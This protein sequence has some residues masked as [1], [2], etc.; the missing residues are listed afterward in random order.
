MILG[1]V[2]GEYNNITAV[3]VIHRDSIACLI[4]QHGPTVTTITTL[5]AHE[6]PTGR[7]RWQRV[8][9]VQVATE[10]VCT[11]PEGCTTAL[12]DAGAPRSEDMRMCISPHRSTTRYLQ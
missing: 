4:N 2:S 6:P 12:S 10:Y 8:Q 9:S 7:I 5:R 11:F 1:K 3:P